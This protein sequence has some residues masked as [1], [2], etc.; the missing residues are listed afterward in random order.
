M[1]FI[2]S[3]VFL[4]WILWFP[5]AMACDPAGKP[6]DTPLEKEIESADAV[7]VAKILKASDGKEFP[8]KV[9]KVFKGK[10]NEGDTLVSGSGADCGLVVR[11]GEIHLIFGYEK[12]GLLSSLRKKE[13]HASGIARSGHIQ[14]SLPTLVKLLSRDPGSKTVP[15]VKEGAMPTYEQYRKC[16]ELGEDQKVIDRCMSEKMACPLVSDSVLQEKCI[17]KAVRLIGKQLG[18]DWF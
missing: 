11:P 2:L 5:L 8:L 3:F 4:L 9:Y 13:F 12:K 16:Y 7:F 6:E 18:V 10:V 1:K 14:S 17:E 15:Q